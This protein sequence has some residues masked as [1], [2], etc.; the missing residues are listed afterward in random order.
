MSGDHGYSPSVFKGQPE[1][2]EQVGLIIEDRYKY[3]RKQ[4]AILTQIR[5][6][7]SEYE[8]ALTKCIEETG[9]NIS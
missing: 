3:L 1:W 8:V 6:K 7:L 4:S 2:A 5:R 9:F